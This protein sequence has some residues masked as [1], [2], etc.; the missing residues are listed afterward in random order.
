V[1]FAAITLCVASQQVFVVVV[2]V[3]FVIDSLRKLLDILPYVVFN[4]D[5]TWNAREQCN[6][7]TA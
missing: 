7:T 6:L 4:N 5:R 1:I 2:F 3:H